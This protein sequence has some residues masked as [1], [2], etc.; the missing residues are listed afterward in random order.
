MSDKSELRTFQEPVGAKLPSTV[1][2]VADRCFPLHVG[3]IELNGQGRI[4]ARDDNEPLRFGFA[5]LGIE[6]RAEVETESQPRVKLI[7]EF[8]KLPYSM[9]IGDGRGLIRRILAASARVPHAQIGLSEFDDMRLEAESSPPSPFTPVSFMA[10]V[11]ALVLDFRPYL[12][13]LARVPAGS[14]QGNAALG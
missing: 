9:E 2:F 7:A 11:T 5:Y 6:F 12:D 1:A 8:G 13:L 14:R 10:T 3:E 4:R